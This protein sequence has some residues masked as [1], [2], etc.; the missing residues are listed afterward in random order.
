LDAFINDEPPAPEPPAPEPPAP[1]PPA[2]EPPAPALTR[3]VSLLDLRL[4][5]DRLPEQW[6]HRYTNEQAV[7]DMREVNRLLAQEVF[8][9]EDAGDQYMIV[10]N[11]DDM[12]SKILRR[13]SKESRREWKG[14]ILRLKGR[15]DTLLCR[16]A[17]LTHA[18]NFSGIQKYSLPKYYY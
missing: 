15:F 5:A 12:G 8:R 14:I 17:I 10:W 1:E 13:C 6:C 11:A 2:P 18:V 9:V 4:F 16:R 3:T 7:S